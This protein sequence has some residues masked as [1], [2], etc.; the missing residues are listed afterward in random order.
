MTKETV[1]FSGF[2]S[3]INNLLSKSIKSH[4]INIDQE[5]KKNSN[6]NIEIKEEIKNMLPIHA[7]LTLYDDKLVDG[8]IFD[9]IIDNDLKNI[10]DV[11][12]LSKIDLKW[13]NSL[14]FTALT[15]T[16]HTDSQTLSRSK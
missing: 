8:S 12:L 14:N 4:S 7:V 6:K 1:D 11:L 5:L 10:K 9:Y 13:K 2:V 3:Q 15:S 16:Y